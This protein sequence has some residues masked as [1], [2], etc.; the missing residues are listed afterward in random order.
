MGDY[1]KKMKINGV[2]INTEV[3]V[4]PGKWLNADSDL[5]DIDILLIHVPEKLIVCI[6]AKDFVESRTVYELIQ[7]NRKIVTKEL[8]HVVKRD[9]WCKKNVL[10]FQKY[11]KEVDENYR[12]QTIFLTYHESAYNYFE[13]EDKN[14]ILFLSAIDLIENPMIVFN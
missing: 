7:Q 2:Y 5:G 13:H 11:V 3:A 14:D 1:Y 9:E 6:E 12:V 4:Q 8:S 10:S